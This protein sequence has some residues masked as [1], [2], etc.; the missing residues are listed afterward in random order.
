ML[1][2]RAVGTLLLAPLSLAC[3]GPGLLSDGSSVSVGNHATG[4]LRHGRRLPPRGEGYLVPRRWLDRQRSFG[5]DELVELLVRAS[6]KVHRAQPGALLGVA[7][8]SPRGGGSTPEHRSHRSGRDV[9][10]LYYALDGRGKPVVP[11]EMLFFDRKGAVARPATQPATPPRRGAPPPPAP[12]EP[13]P[14][15]SAPAT[16]DL[17]RTWAMV[18]ALI[19]D[20]QV[21]VQWIFVGRPIADLLLQHARRRR[22]PAHILE[23]AA[24]VMHQP[25]DAQTHMDHWHVR[26]FCAASDRSQGCKDRGPARWMK[27]DLKYV[28]EP[29]E[30]DPPLDVAM[31]TLRPFWAARTGSR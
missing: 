14:D 20:P 6:R 16:L 15:P 24:A 17:P 21:S 11:A 2:L 12:P 25:S 26:V 10:L 1:S 19:T 7:D 18:R 13:P 4:A 30:P 22:E 29:G 5:T 27:K 3:V 28:D 9:D 8:L 23:R 31:I